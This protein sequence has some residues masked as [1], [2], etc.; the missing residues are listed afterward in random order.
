MS[1]PSD[2]QFLI[3]FRIWTALSMIWKNQWLQFL[4]SAYQKTE[5][6]FFAGFCQLGSFF[7][8][9]HL[10]QIPTCICPKEQSLHYQFCLKIGINRPI[11]NAWCFYMCLTICLCYFGIRKI[12]TNDMSQRVRSWY[13]QHS[14]RNL[15]S[16]I[17]AKQ[18]ML[19]VL[20]SFLYVKVLTIYEINRYND[21]QH[22]P[23]FGVQSK[24]IYDK[25]Q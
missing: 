19:S 21:A 10:F 13:K 9:F 18:V 17:S 25:Q 11:K 15:V 1:A 20:G 12:S 6:L 8:S 24:Q 5:S 7:P 22:L 14:V 3:K 2:I 16:L 4:K 23:I